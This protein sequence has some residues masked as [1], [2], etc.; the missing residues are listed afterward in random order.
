MSEATIAQMIREGWTPATHDGDG[1]TADGMMKVSVIV[2]VLR[3][4]C[5]PLLDMPGNVDATVLIDADAW[6]EHG[7]PILHHVISWRIDRDDDEDNALYEGRSLS[8]SD[9]VDAVSARLFLLA[10][11]KG[12]IYRVPE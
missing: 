10:I 3:W 12:P 11:G 4:Y 9:A 2:Q 5:P 8:V 6:L 1:G 7:K